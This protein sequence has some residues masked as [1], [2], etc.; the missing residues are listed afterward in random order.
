MLKDGQTYFKVCLG[1]YNIMHERV[2]SAN[3]IS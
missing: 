2:K 1:F 3:A